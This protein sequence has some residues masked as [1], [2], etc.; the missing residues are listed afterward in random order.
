[1]LEKPISVQIANN[2]ARIE[3]L[4]VRVKVTKS[5]K[6]WKSLSFVKLN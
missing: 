6:Y 1:M 3:A 4:G 5:L 2:R